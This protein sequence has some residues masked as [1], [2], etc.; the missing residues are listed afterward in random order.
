MAHDETANPPA[1][2]GAEGLSLSALS[3]RNRFNAEVLWNLGSVAVLGVCGIVVNFVIARWSGAAALGVFNQVYAAYIV[4]SQLAVGGVHLSVLK[5][6]SHHQDDRETVGHIAFAAMLL[7]TMLSTV[8]AIATWACGGWIGALLSSPDVAAGLA[9]AA[10]GL[11]FF[12]LNKILLNVLNGLRMMRSFAVFQAF[13]FLFILATVI[14]VLALRRPAPE[15]A[16][17]LTLSELALFFM[18][19]AFVHFAGAPL[20]PVSPKSTWIREHASFGARG[21]FGGLLSEMNTRVDVLMLGY[22]TTDA[23]VGVYSFAAIIAEGFAQIPLVVRRNL[24]PIFGRAFA[25]R[26]VPRITEA[27]RKV[28]RVLYPLMT[29]ICVAAV[30]LYPLLLRMAGAGQELSESW[31]V[32]AILMAGILVNAGYRPCMGVFLQGG[33]PAAYTGLILIAVLGNVALNAVLIPFM[34]IYGAA[35]ATA[36]VFVVEAGLILVLARRLLNVRL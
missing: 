22:F 8:L 33:R 30:A 11:I 6:V 36:A 1:E 18:L 12:S 9:L 10:P 35:T 26:A 5:H 27:A 19:T 28:R 15:L 13:R 21:F 29:L 34:G 31:A 32:F 25:E 3:P 14:V 24:D 2:P 17:S 7:G 20:R 16:L 4:L 23:A